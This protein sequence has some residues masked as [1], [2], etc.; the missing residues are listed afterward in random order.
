MRQ[1]TITILCLAC[2][3]FILCCSKGGNSPSTSTD[4]SA[5][6][7]SPPPANL[8]K[9]KVFSGVQHMV[10]PI[11]KGHLPESSY[12]TYT[13]RDSLIN[14]YW[15]KK[16][17]R[18]YALITNYDLTELF[19][20]STDTTKAIIKV[21]KIDDLVK[22]KIE[23]LVYDAKIL[24]KVEEEQVYYYILDRPNFDKR[25]LTHD[26]NTPPDGMLYT[27]EGDKDTRA[28]TARLGKKENNYYLLLNSTYVYFLNMHKATGS[29]HGGDA[30]IKIP[31]P[32]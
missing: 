6:N 1:F 23:W 19:N 5:Q 21:S 25:Y 28:I 20:S 32:K 8:F 9:P 3:S 16:G 10:F 4:G 11:P 31:P 29:G 12:F 30:G 7:Q 24:E 15:Q 26:T 27:V 14:E 13:Q 17:E 18:S 22:V 2:L